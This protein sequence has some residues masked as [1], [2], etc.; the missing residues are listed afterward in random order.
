MK[1]RSLGSQKKMRWK[2]L[3]IPEVADSTTRRRL[4]F[5]RTLVIALPV[6]GVAYVVLAAL[7]LQPFL[8]QM[9]RDMVI[10]VMS[11]AVV[12]TLVRKGRQRLAGW[13]LVMVLWGIQA[14]FA[15]TGGGIVGS[16]YFPLIAVMIVAVFFIG[17]SAGFILFA[18]NVAFGSLLLAAHRYGW[19]PP[20]AAP[21]EPVNILIDTTV[22]ALLILFFLVMEQR[23]SAQDARMIEQ[24]LRE[25]KA[26]EQDLGDKL[27]R[28]RLLRDLGLAYAQH[29]DLKELCQ[30]VYAAVPQYTGIDRASILFFDPSRN[31]L[32][33][34]GFFG[35]Y[36]PDV[37]TTLESQPIDMSVSGLCFRSGKSVLINDCSTTNIIPQR[38]VEQLRL[39]SVLAVPIVMKDRPLGVLRIDDT[40]RANR[41]SETDVEF[42]EMVADQ[43]AVA[44][45]NFHLFENQTRTAKALAESE[46]R[47]RGLI[48]NAVQLIAEVDEAGTMIFANPSHEFVLGFSASSLVGKTVQ[49]FIHPEDLAEATVALRDLKRSARFRFRHADG[50]WRWL[51][52]SGQRFESS[53]G[54]RYVIVSTDISEQIRNEQTKRDL[55]EQLLQSQKLEAIGT[56]AGGIAHDFNNILASMFGNIELA[57]MKVQSGK[58]IDVYLDRLLEAS[59]R[60]RD[61]VKQILAF[62]R[63]QELERKPISLNQTVHEALNLMRASLS[64]TIEIVEEIPR[65]ELRIRGDATQIH[66]V[67]INLCTN[68]AHAMKE[69]QGTITVRIESMEVDE[70]KSRQ[71]PGISP[72]RYFCLTVRDTGHGMDGL[73]LRRIFEPFFTTKALGKGTGLGLSMVHGIVSQHDGGIAVESEP[74]KGTS[75]SIYLPP[76]ADESTAAATSTGAP[77]RGSG[78][79]ILLLDDEA[80]LNEVLSDLLMTGG[81]MV[82]GVTDGE[83]AL[84]ELRANPKKFSAVVTDYMMPRMNG[85]TIASLARD[86]RP[87]IP[88]V[89]LT[90]HGESAELERRTNL[91]IDALL[92]KPVTH[93][94]LMETL[95][96][97]LQSRSAGK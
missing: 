82:T 68:A 70:L 25:R 48:D 7:F 69:N 27:K 13:I 56:L 46:K 89:L 52:A 19:L 37:G 36:R 42:F 15:W 26:T 10:L 96:A 44:I 77:P 75:F 80:E 71:I 78:E 9:M 4:L 39:K 81:Y 83:Q 92:L 43:L 74:G 14:S 53:E 49:E 45:E 17:R 34:D 73:M 22:A 85:L 35:I 31:A 61:L 54:I 30:R 28:L 1:K 8:Y 47:Y 95:A 41:F 58:P 59:E 23:H 62:S 11:S 29:L 64:K 3:D 50:S 38:F 55:E 51:E 84:R 65:D 33:G 21:T 66:Q 91:P 63:K 67:V 60:A 97:V 93:R 87:D 86:I 76:C 72:G 32:L 18:L 57:K 24:E 5:L 16:G 88:I 6:F 12:W 40:K 94:S 90:G 2:F 79:W 20:P